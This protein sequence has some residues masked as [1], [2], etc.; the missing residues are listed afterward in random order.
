VVEA[1]PPAPELDERESARQLS[2][3]PIFDERPI[4]LN[5]NCNNGSH[6]ATEKNGG[7]GEIQRGSSVL[8]VLLRV[9][10]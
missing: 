1:E 8:S 5:T 7:N 9:S 6:G 10:V 2:A 3:A 4:R